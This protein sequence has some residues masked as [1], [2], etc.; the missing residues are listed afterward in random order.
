M[1]PRRRHRGRRQG[2]TSLIEVLVTVV[3]IVVGLL[4]MAGIQVRSQTLELE[5]YQRGQALILLQDMVDRMNGNAANAASYVTA[6][7][8]TDAVDED[9]CSDLAT[10]AAVDL[11]EWSKALKGSSEVSGG[12]TKGA[13]IDGRGCVTALAAGTT[14][15]VA[16]AWQGM[17]TTVPPVSDCGEDSYDS[18]ASRRA[19]TAVVQVPNLGAL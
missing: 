6:A 14:Y 10:R 18:E 7:V 15:L 11:C 19:V 9:D 16:V 1:N 3:I 17:S 5:S 12:V 4:G 8:G 13:M 2:G